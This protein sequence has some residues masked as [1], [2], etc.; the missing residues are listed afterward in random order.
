MNI[1]QQAALFYHKL[2]KS[3][4]YMKPKSTQDKF[5]TALKEFLDDI[6]RSDN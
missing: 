4:F 5:E 6:K 2:Y 3:N 1:T